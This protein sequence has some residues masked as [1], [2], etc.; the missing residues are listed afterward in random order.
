MEQVKVPNRYMKKFDSNFSKID[1]PLHGVRLPDFKIED[2]IKDSY[3]LSSKASNYEFLL[4]VCRE[5]FKKFDIPKEQHSE[6]GKRVKSELS[7]IKELGF[8]DYILLVWTVINHCKETDIAVGLGRGSAAGSLVLYLLGVT[9]VDPIK[10]GLFFERFISKIRA[11]KQ[12][13]DGITYLDGSL[14]CDVDIDICY[15]SR[16]KVIKF[17][18]KLFEGRTSKILTL[19]T[20]SGKLL[21]KECGKIIEEKAETEMNEVSSLIPKVFGQVQDLKTAHEE[22]EDFR[23]WCDENP[24]VYETALKLRSL[25]KNKSVHASGMMLSYDPIMESCPTELTSDKERVSTYD[26]NWASI[27]NVKLDLLGLRSVSIVDRVCKLVGIAVS[28]VDF[29]DPFIYQQLQD[30]KNPH[31][32]FQIEAETNFKVCRKV[33]PK[34]LEELSGVLALARPGAL[35]FVDQYSNYTNND[36][37]EP[38]HPFFDSVLSSSGGVALYQ[39]QLMQMSHKIGFTLDEAEVLR[40]I[41]GK[42]KIEE[43]KKWKQKI[44]D[45]IKEK[46]LDPEIG[47]ILWRILENSANYS[48]NKSH[49][50][51]YAALAASTIYLKFKYPQHFFLALLEMTK[52]EPSPLEEVSKI[53][54]ELHRFNIELLGPHIIKSD[55]DFSLEDNNI[56]FGLSSIKGIS[57]KTMEKLKDFKSENSNKFEVFQG[58][59]GAGLNIGALSAL[60]Q[61]GALE[62]LSKSR[63]R[64]VL[65]AQLWNLLTDKEKCLCFDL[66]EEFNFDL[67]KIIKHLSVSKNENGKLLIRES[68]VKTIKRKYDPYL[69]IYRQNNQSESFAN[70][71][72]ENKLLGYSYNKSLKEIF[73]S[74]IRNLKNSIEVD[75][76]EID[77]VVFMVAKVDKASQWVAR[78]EKKTRTMKLILSDQ[79]GTIPLLAFNNK[80]DYIKTCNNDNLPK[81]NDIVIVKAQKKQDCLFADTVSIQTLKIYT[82]LSELKNI[83]KEKSS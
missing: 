19:T 39:E 49:S 27:F 62:E 23:N 80:I 25:I 67:F 83:E 48:F 81:D 12:V 57:E 79:W 30:L 56:R 77:S 40:R 6:Y 13:V 5:N 1:I 41:V 31:G 28:D 21:I 14:M 50:M 18:E 16:H 37:Y 15:Y 44:S 76:E 53:Q 35:E 32:I 42:K 26:M 63:S 22:Q 33:C 72:Y 9:K 55:S 34:N 46:N 70:W 36:V 82:K 65:E 74:K 38:I 78:N 69:Q 29:N 2:R 10:Y 71:F 20:L 61:A 51:C 8:V 75:Q 7:T 17:I 45:K 68:R 59:K 43:V 4:K 73:S 58:A 54:K 64:V 24:R 66:S 11:K 52:H 60:I 47:D 3:G